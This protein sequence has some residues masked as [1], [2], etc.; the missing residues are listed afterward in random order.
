LI[1]TEGAQ[2]NVPVRVPWIVVPIRGTG[3]G[4]GAVI[5]VAT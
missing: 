1:L 4:E 3:T 5:A 2:P